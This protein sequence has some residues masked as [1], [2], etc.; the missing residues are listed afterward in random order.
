MSQVPITP[1]VWEDSSTW[2]PKIRSFLCSRLRP[3]A[4]AIWQS[5]N[6]L[7]DL[8]LDDSEWLEM[9]ESSLQGGFEETCTD[10]VEH[11][12]IFDLQVF[13]ACRP[14][15]VGEYIRGGVSVASW[16]ARRHNLF[17]LIR[18]LKIVQKDA[19]ILSQSFE[20][21]A[22]E[23][24]I[25][26][27][28]LFVAVDPRH[29]IQFCGHYFILGSEWIASHIGQTYYPALRERGIP[30][31]LHLRLPLRWTSSRDRKEFTREIFREWTR[32]T[33]LRESSVRD[34]DFTFR[35]TTAIPP[36]NLLDHTHP[37]Q[38]PDPHHP[39][40][41]GTVWRNPN[42]RCPHCVRYRRESRKQT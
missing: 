33:T 36:E 31:L 40:G 18:D 42:I 2:L 12:E 21:L 28:A 29:L 34:I 30:T 19:D 7:D 35:L 27:D 23:N 22:S 32:L 17:E 6:D 16:D 11:L 20:K 10:F 39:H 1:I 8:Y 14:V 25:D 5:R 37:E 4:I 41:W 38:I 9:L 24:D 15:D 3:D 26:L 13:H